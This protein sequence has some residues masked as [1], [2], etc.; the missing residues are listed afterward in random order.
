MY[1][2]CASNIYNNIIQLFH[3]GI[4]N[5]LPPLCN[6][7]VKR[8]DRQFHWTVADDTVAVNKVYC[9]SVDTA[10]LRTVL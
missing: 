9:V 6:H 7:E 10:H 3:N 4:R 8:M 1:K 5:K 2:L